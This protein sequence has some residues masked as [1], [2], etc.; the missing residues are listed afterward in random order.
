MGLLNEFKKLFFAAESVSKSAANKAT[1]AGKEAGQQMKNRADELFDDAREA[2]TDF[3]EDVQ[4][5]AGQAWN[6]AKDTL[7]DV[8]DTFM[9]RTEGVRKQAGDFTEKVGKDVLDKTAPLRG[10]MEHTAESVGKDILE[11]GGNAVERTKDL[12]EGIG[13]RILGTT[14]QAKAKTTD[15]SQDTYSS[16]EDFA[17]GAADDAFTA[18][19]DMAE[20]AKAKMDAADSSLD[21]MLEKAKDV[22][23]NLS[24]K[25]QDTFADLSAKA[26]AADAAEAKAKASPKIGYDNLK[27][28]L[29]DGQ[30]DFF[31]K[32]ERFAQGDYHDK[33]TKK[34]AE[35]SI[36]DVGDIKITRDPNYQRTP[37]EG[38][39]AGFEDLDGDGNEIIDD[40]IIEEDE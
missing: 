33:D 30:D 40:A 34:P 36:G 25:V 39:V 24:H 2:A 14:K 29:L 3:G 37:T 19:N 31:A 23:E 26:A 1:D 18:K 27:G 9:E 11:K 6:K 20:Q 8:G 38:T 15:Y 35:E 12:A 4:A 21:D 10:K 13:A 7:D 16:A 22:G 17:K 28:S 32:A 5:K